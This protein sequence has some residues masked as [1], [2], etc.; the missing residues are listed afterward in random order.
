[1]R[2]RVGVLGG[3]F[4]PIHKAHLAVARQARE[5]FSLDRVLLIPAANPPHKQDRLTEDW[6]HRFRMVELACRRKPGM[7]A[8]P[9]ES[10]RTRHCGTGSTEERKS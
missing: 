3:T 2:Q 8:S 6:R 10:G 1:M 4:D 5:T 9:L 7:V